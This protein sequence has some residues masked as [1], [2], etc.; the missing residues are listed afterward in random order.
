MATAASIEDLLKAGVHFGHLT[1][2]WNPKMKEFIFMHRNGIHILDLN[3]T[4]E[5]LQESLDEIVKV[6]RSGKKVMFVGTK[7]Q[8]QEIIRTQAER[9]DMPYVTDRWLGGMLTNFQTIR[10]SISRM[11]EID[12]MERDGTF[13]SITKKERLML[14]REREKLTKVLA[15]ISKISRLPGALFVVDIVKENIAVNEA[16]KLNIPIIAMVDTNCD[17]DIPD[18][19][20]PSNDDAAKSINLIASNIADAIIEGAAERESYQEEQFALE[21]ME[22]KEEQT[23]EQEELTPEDEGE[24]PTRRKRPRR[25]T[26]AGGGSGSGKPGSDRKTSERKG[27]AR[28][29]S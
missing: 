26:G 11:D 2:R 27:S 8:A 22:K 16:L 17:P 6:S 1:R 14:T 15:G 18:F 10:K 3:K 20:I 9:C 21:T 28:K 19:I 5:L 23:K 13:E 29:D 24:K 12:T 25:Q 4:R 7:K